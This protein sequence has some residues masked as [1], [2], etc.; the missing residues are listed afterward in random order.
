MGNRSQDWLS[1]ARRDFEQAQDSKAAGRHEWACFAAQ[2]SAEKT[3][4]ALHLHF[5]QEA[6]GHVIAKLLKELPDV[7]IPST[8]VDK[9]KVLDN[10]YIPLRYPDSYPEGAPFEHFGILQSDEAIKYAG[11]IIEFVSEKM[12]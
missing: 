12:A 7:D 10:S 4:K 9:A 11:E 1:Q 3:V 8:L 6:W 5:G 2:Q